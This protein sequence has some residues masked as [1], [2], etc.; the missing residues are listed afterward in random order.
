[1]K[2]VL[3][4]FRVLA[5]NN[6]RAWF[7]A[8]K[9]RYLEV[10][11]IHEAFTGKLIERLAAFDATIAGVAVKDCVFRVYRD[12]RFSGDKRP[13]KTHA[14]AFIARGGRMAPRGGYYLHVQPG[15]CLLAGG[16]WCPDAA[17]LKALRRDVFESFE[18]FESIVHAPAFARYYSLDEETSLKRV[19][20]PFPADAPGARWTRLRSYTA[21]CPLP[22]DFLDGEDAVERCA[23]RL[24]LLYPL[25]RF[26]N[27]TVEETMAPGKG[28]LAGE[29]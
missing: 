22:D 12:T 28:T 26:L 7:Q 10:K 15:N 29:M 19:P 3:E 17:L 8:N 23:A 20:P 11:A 14:G 18:E 6:D 16:I 25:N 24:Q 5:A 1:M 9:A 27:Y 13:Y 21:S 4:F 2:E